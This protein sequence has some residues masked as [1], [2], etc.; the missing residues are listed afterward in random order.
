MDGCDVATGGGFCAGT[1]ALG[2]DVGT[3]WDGAGAGAGVGADAGAFCAALFG[4]DPPH[5]ARVAANTHAAKPA[6]FR[7]DTNADTIMA[8]SLA[9]HPAHRY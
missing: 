9:I 6:N 5:A 7:D 3:D 8:F 1:V 4:D 2:P